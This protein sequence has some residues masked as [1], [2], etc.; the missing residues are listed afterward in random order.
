MFLCRCFF[1]FCFH[2]VCD[3]SNGANW[4]SKM[5]RKG[6]ALVE[7]TTFLGIF[8][9]LTLAIKSQWGMCLGYF[10]IQAQVFW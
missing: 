3:W 7:N 9:G 10:P 5:P 4:V 8:I 2:V 1:P 6:V